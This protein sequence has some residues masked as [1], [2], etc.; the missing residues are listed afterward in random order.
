M[1]IEDLAA[2]VTEA[3]TRAES[4]F[5]A[6]ADPDG[7]TGGHVNSAAEA[8]RAIAAR[9][10]QL[11]GAMASAQDE[12]LT[13]AGDRL[14]HAAT[15]EADLAERIRQATQAHEAGRSAASGL[16][17]SAADLPAALG[18]TAHVPAGEFVALTVLRNRVGR[19]QHLLAQ[20]AAESARLAGEIR[21]LGYG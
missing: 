7:S 3:L 18:P 9:T 2:R 4:L 5:C 10:A 1:P 8:H 12:A 14:D 20:H 11:S 21:G 17:A 19:M 16:R 15:S 6:P 13:A